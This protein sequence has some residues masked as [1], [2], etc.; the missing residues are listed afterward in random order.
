MPKSPL[1]NEVCTMHTYGMA[2]GKRLAATA[3]ALR[4]AD[5]STSEGFAA[6]VERGMTD[7]GLVDGD[8]SKRIGISRTTVQRWRNGSSVPHQLMRPQV[9]G[10]LIRMCEQ[11]AT[12]VR[13]RGVLY[14]RLPGLEALPP[15]TDEILSGVDDGIAHPELPKPKLIRSKKHLQK[16]QDSR[17]ATLGC[18]TRISKSA[19]QAVRDSMAE[20]GSTPTF[21]AIGIGD[22][23]IRRALK[24]GSATRRVADAI[25]SFAQKR[26][27]HGQG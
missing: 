1:A 26:G 27:K 10:V 11:D 7:L 8:L 12:L 17:R 19:L 4:S 16:I 13:N 23:L 15:D 22:D 5:V 20:N 3:E 21:R 25:E 2:M 14:T 24:T 9:I 6:A 18:N